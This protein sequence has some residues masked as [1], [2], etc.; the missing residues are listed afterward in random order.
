MKIKVLSLLVLILCLFGCNYI[1]S[2]I[3]I[4]DN[5]VVLKENS[6]IFI[7]P[8]PQ[9][10]SLNLEEIDGGA[11]VQIIEEKDEWVYVKYS[12]GEGWVPKWYVL[13]DESK[14]IKDINSETRVLNQDIWG[15]LYPN[16]TKIVNLKKGKLLTPIKEWNGW[17]EVKIIVYDIPEVHIA[18]VP[19]N[20]LSP[21]NEIQPI[22]GYLL[23]GTEVH[24]ISE[25][26]DISLT[27]SKN[28]TYEM[29]VFI[30]SEKDDYVLVGAN[31]GW[32]AWTKKNTLIYIK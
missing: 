5:S 3:D 7:Y 11:K 31:G 6:K 28:I 8:S 25:F 19:Q 20:A 27:N 2:S 29:N 26:E 12:G 24:E 18:W 4:D 9:P 15:S 1:Q 21:V 32:S 22:E 30:I 23:S 13:S 16:G 17:Y 10:E 14:Q